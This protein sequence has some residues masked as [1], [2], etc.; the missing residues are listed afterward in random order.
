M[1]LESIVQNPETFTNAET[2]RINKLANGSIPNEEITQEDVT[3]YARWQS[4]QAVLSAQYEAERAAA[5]AE[6]QARIE[7]AEAVKNAAVAN[8]EAQTNLAFARLEMIK[9]GEIA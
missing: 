9:N 4:W 1:T 3:L 7:Q 2:D 8:L 5:A 6:A